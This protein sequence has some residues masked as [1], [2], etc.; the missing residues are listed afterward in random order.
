M[1]QAIDDVRRLLAGFREARAGF[2]GD[3]A[4]ASL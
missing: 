2:E 4:A 1:D 3:H